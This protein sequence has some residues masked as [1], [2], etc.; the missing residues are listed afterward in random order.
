MIAAV[1]GRRY[2]AA[3]GG[4]APSYAGVVPLADIM[5]SPNGGRNG[6]WDPPDNYMKVWNESR[7][8]PAG[9]ER[10]KLFAEMHRIMLEEWVPTVPFYGV[11]QTKFY[12]NY[13]HNWN[14][15]AQ[16]IFSNNKFEDVWLDS[17]APEK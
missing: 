3:M 11:A 16:E 5:Y 14:L 6:G 15:V 9:P 10:D 8:L 7:T 2:D 17:D 12:W 13:V 1:E 4:T